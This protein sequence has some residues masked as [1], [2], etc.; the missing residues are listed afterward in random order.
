VLSVLAILVVGAGPPSVLAILLPGGAGAVL[1]RREDTPQDTSLCQRGHSE[2][3]CDR[4]PSPPRSGAAARS[5]NPRPHEIP[6]MPAATPPDHY[7]PPRRRSAPPLASGRSQWSGAPAHGTRR[8]T[9]TP[10]ER[11][12]RH[13][14]A[15]SLGNARGYRSVSERSIDYPQGAARWHPV[16]AY[17]TPCAGHFPRTC[18]TSPIF[19]A[20]NRSWIFLTAPC[21]AACAAPP[22]RPALELPLR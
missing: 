10:T 22:T 4:Q 12:S 19:S 15:R 2:P 21:A 16:A 1:W 17:A 18:S 14:P 13:P 6:T 7:Q 5:A 3:P 9:S 20:G 8:P 11:P